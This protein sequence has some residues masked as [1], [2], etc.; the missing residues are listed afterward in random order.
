MIAGS[1][2]LILFDSGHPS[3]WWYKSVTM[4]VDHFSHFLHAHCHEQVSIQSA[5]ESK[6]N[7]EL[8]TKWCNVQIKHT[9]SNNSM[10]MTK[11][12]KDHI[13][14]CNQQQTF[15][16]VSK[17]WQNGM[18]EHYIGVITT[19]ACTMLLHAMQMWPN[20][21]TS[22]LFTQLHPMVK[23]NKVTFHSL[24]RWRYKSNTTWFQSVWVSSLCSQPIFAI[25][26]SWS[27]KME[28]K[29]LPGCIHW[30]FATPCKQC[31]PCVQPK[32]STGVPT[33]PCH[34]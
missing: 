2:G 26:H 22:E 19:C 23:Q 10:F 16:G 25:R 1:P 4:W 7:F 6:E 28:R 31:H 14:A 32:D 29:I 12:F 15:C 27:W 9:H 34:S 24:H 20:I 5:L 8:F 21:I 11:A 30:P 13:A 18:I 3:T 17:H 33:I